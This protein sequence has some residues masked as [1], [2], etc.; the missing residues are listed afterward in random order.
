MEDLASWWSEILTATGPGPAESVAVTVDGRELLRLDSR[1]ASVQ[2]RVDRVSVTV[3]RA[4]RNKP[5]AAVE[6]VARDGAGVIV[7]R[8]SAAGTLA[9]VAASQGPGIAWDRMLDAALVTGREYSRIGIEA[10][11]RAS[12][13]VQALAERMA[14]ENDRLRT[15]IDALEARLADTSDLREDLREQV[16]ARRIEDAEAAAREAISEAQDEQR[17]ELWSLGTHAVRAFALSAA[18]AAARPAAAVE[19]L[20]KLVSTLSADQL[21]PMMEPLNEGQRVELLQI[22]SV[23]Q[24]AQK[25]EKP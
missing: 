8:W 14:Q 6:L 20:Q 25:E 19:A 22:L 11:D 15:R 16:A 21:A 13:T 3:A 5:S 10:T 12:K 9:P 17:R 24:D 23:L 1:G 18:P 4:L 7:D 2:D